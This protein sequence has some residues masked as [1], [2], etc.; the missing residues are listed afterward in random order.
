MEGMMVMKI[1]MMK[2]ERMMVIL[3][4]ERTG[5]AIRLIPIEEK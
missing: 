2:M 4:I 5:M 3:K 1:E